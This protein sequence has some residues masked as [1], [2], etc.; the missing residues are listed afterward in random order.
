MLPTKF[1]F[2]WPSGFREEDFLDINQNKR[3]QRKGYNHQ[4]QIPHAGTDI[5]KDSFIPSTLRDW[6]QLDPGCLHI[7]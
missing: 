3:K 5:F 4:F 6:N 7:H 1:P 2:I